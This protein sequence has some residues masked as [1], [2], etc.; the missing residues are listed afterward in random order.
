MK[1]K[2]YRHCKNYCPIYSAI[3]QYNSNHGHTISCTVGMC[4]EI[5]KV[6]MKNDEEYELEMQNKKGGAE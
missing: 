3:R 4:E 5:T 2:D 1:D 6:V